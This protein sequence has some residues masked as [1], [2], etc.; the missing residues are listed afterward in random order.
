VKSEHDAYGRMILDALDG[1][2]TF[3]IVERDD[4]YI[5]AGRFGT[6]LYLAPYRKWPSRQRR[7]MRFVRGRVLDIGT[8]GGRVPLHL[9]QAGHDVVAV[10]ISPGAI[11]AAKRQGV[12]DA[13][14][15]AIEDL[16]DSIGPIDTVVMFGNNFGLF[17][18]RAKGRRI[19]KHLHGLTTDRARIL[20]ESNDPYRTDDQDHLAYHQRNLRRGRMA[21]Q[22]RIRVRY[23]DLTTPWFDYLL[24]SVAE[25]EELVDGTGWEVVRIIN[26][27][28]GLYVAVLE[29]TAPAK[30]GRGR[31]ARSGAAK[32][33]SAATSRRSGRRPRRSGHASS[34]A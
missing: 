13:R 7:G 26:G 29:K 21:G 2:E 18:G 10:D 3:E 19:L 32:K 15:L 14:V 20:A 5:S 24:V 30:A 1:E 22:L 12:K 34:R 9:E 31:A 27:E 11:E 17:A 23:R 28:P 8:G 33:P 16:D 25:M 4:G 6:A